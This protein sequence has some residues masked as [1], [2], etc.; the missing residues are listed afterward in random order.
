MAT[1]IFRNN[2]K[3]SSFPVAVVTD[4]G[5]V[6]RYNLSPSE[7]FSMDGVSLTPETSS[8][9]AKKY[10]TL[11]STAP[12]EEVEVPTSEGLP[13][14][15][16]G[17]WTSGI[18]Y[19]KGCVVSYSGQNYV[20]IVTH[21]SSQN[22]VDDTTNY[23]TLSV[24]SPE[25]FFG[26]NPAT[27]AEDELLVKTPSGWEAK[28]ISDANIGTVTM[29]AIQGLVAGLA[30][31]IG[32]GDT[33]ANFQV[34]DAPVN[35]TDVTNKT[36]VDTKLSKAGGVM[37]GPIT[38][39]SGLLPL[40][41]G[42]MSGAISSP[43][44][45]TTDDHL[46]RKAYVQANFVP[47][48]GGVVTGQISSTPA[49]TPTA[50][51]H[52]VNKG[53][54]DGKSE[55]WLEGGTMTGPVILSGAPVVDLGAATKKYTDD[56]LNSRLSSSGGTVTGDLE[57]AGV[58]TVDGSEVVTEATLDLGNFASTVNFSSTARFL[59]D[60]YFDHLS[61]TSIG[62]T[63]IEVDTLSSIDAGITGTFGF[64]GTDFSM[65]GAI[66]E[67]LGNASSS[68]DAVSK[69]Y[70]DDRYLQ[71]S[72][73][74]RM[75][76]ELLLE[77]G[78][79]DSFGGLKE[80]FYTGSMQYKGAQVV[81]RKK[82]KRITTDYEVELDVGVVLVDTGL[83]MV[84]VYLPTYANQSEI[85]V[86][87][88]GGMG[89][90]VVVLRDTRDKVN[91]Q[92]IVGSYVNDF[93]V[94]MIT[95]TSDG[96]S[97]CFSPSTE[98][99]V[100]AGNPSDGFLW[101]LTD[102][103]INDNYSSVNF[104]LDGD[105]VSSSQGGIT[106]AVTGSSKMRVPV[107]VTGHYK[108][109][110]VV[111]LTASGYDTYSRVELVS[112][113]G[114]YVELDVAGS[115]LNPATIYYNYAGVTTSVYDSVLD[116]YIVTG[117]ADVGGYAK[118]S[119]DSAL[120]ITG[121]LNGDNVRLR[122]HDDYNAVGAVV[123]TGVGY[124]TTNLAFSTST[125]VDTIIEVINRDVPTKSQYVGIVVSSD[126][127]NFV[128]PVHQFDI[129]SSTN[130]GADIV[131]DVPGTSGF[132][133]GA[134]VNVFG[135]YSGVYL[136]TSVSESSLVLPPAFTGTGVGFVQQSTGNLTSTWG[137][138]TAKSAQNSHI[139]LRTAL[140]GVST[141]RVSGW[142]PLALR[143]FSVSN[144]IA[145]IEGWNSFNGTVSRVKLSPTA[146]AISATYLVLKF[147]L[148]KD[149]D[150]GI[151]SLFHVGD[152]ITWS[153]LSG[154][155]SA[156]AQTDSVIQTI[157]EDATYTMVKTSY[158][159]GSAGSINS[160]GVTNLKTSGDVQINMLNLKSKNWMVEGSLLKVTTY[161]T[162]DAFDTMSFYTQA[163]NNNTY[164]LSGILQSTYVTFEKAPSTMGDSTLACR[165]SV[166]G[167]VVN[168]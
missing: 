111:H 78:S 15:W 161:D 141:L 64:T 120:S 104:A 62:S 154:G 145:P 63:L 14:V 92:S 45:P 68:G 71:V 75:E 86:K 81:T 128:S 115:V 137:I 44:N 89:P 130:G 95:I 124:I 122:G 54:T 103:N 106:T 39:A 19:N 150:G 26:I 158:V 1:Y 3:T 100:T 12:T 156:S 22:P 55:E 5:S 35:P 149:Y 36:Y 66:I 148:M 50:I 73:A 82:V 163:R 67:G 133:A 136:T 23:S 107:S 118:F 30:S 96:E 58:L 98:Y 144:K 142:E 61:A 116:A 88:I 152:K 16:T 79:G 123:D 117:V 57:V 37:T 167:L 164:S 21:K 165:V 27:W 8:V 10:V 138:S 60:A 101:V 2:S 59:D 94:E 134:Q 114:G 105:I 121:I 125:S 7:I 40:A 6:R 90:C 131:V 34:S 33:V 46:T 53:Y 119:F 166:E 25:T 99:E 80:D 91:L 147:P 24:E 70:G 65:G 126:F 76:G 112:S 155:G 18:Y 28:K 4:S 17:A 129:S 29:G 83:S 135:D 49:S 11:L 13:M 140:S 43:V 20:T 109:G 41:G 74:N 87:K 108:V 52:L 69:G 159:G 157:T 77:N 160:G 47:K 56:G 162:L 113:S 9:V 153:A 85:T 51:E 93:A 146:V 139:T 42:T 168:L 151:C 110:D 31:K 48:A 32:E 97:V 72:G 132:D 127:D 38:G 84:T 102:R 143:P